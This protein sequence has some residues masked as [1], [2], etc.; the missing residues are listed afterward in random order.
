MQPTVGTYSRLSA[1]TY[2]QA[3]IRI[4][5][6]SYGCPFAFL[7]LQL[8]V[9]FCNQSYI[10]LFIRLSVQPYSYTIKIQCKG[11]LKT[12]GIYPVFI[13]CP[14]IAPVV[15]PCCFD[16]FTKRRKIPSNF[17]A[18]FKQQ[19]ISCKKQDIYTSRRAVQK[20]AKSIGLTPKPALAG[21][22]LHLQTASCVLCCKLR[23]CSTKQLA[24]AP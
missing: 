20:T 13:K 4:Y 24:P 5:C 19:F 22:C 16:T 3:N 7:Y 2:R 15:S 14:R 18:N 10:C 8:Y 9:S 12:I 17:A 21:F 11:I 23:F 1:P 6:C